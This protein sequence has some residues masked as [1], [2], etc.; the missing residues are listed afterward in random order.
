[1]TRMLVLKCLSDETGDDAAEIAADDGVD[2]D[3]REFVHVVNR[4]ESY[5]DC[6]LSMRAEPVDR[7]V[8]SELVERVTASSAPSSR[9]SAEDRHG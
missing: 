4:L 9:P 1:M 6:T 2:V 7:F 5:F 3:G 8:L